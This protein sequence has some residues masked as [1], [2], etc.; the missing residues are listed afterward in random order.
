MKAAAA[1]FKPWD[2]R[3]L[4]EIDRLLCE[5][6]WRTKRKKEKMGAPYVFMGYSLDRLL[7]LTEAEGRLIDETPARPRTALDARSGL[8]PS[9]ASEPSRKRRGKQL[10][11]EEAEIQRKA[12]LLYPSLRNRRREDQ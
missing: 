1:T 5:V 6:I 11:P 2:R 3:K 8:P 12:E 7:L 9:T 10:S 4:S